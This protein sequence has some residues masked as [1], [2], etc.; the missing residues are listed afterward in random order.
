MSQLTVDAVRTMREAVEGMAHNVT[1]IYSCMVT[2][3][4][5]LAALEDVL[6]CPDDAPDRPEITE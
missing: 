5:A 1:C 2:L 6:E 4:G 3:I